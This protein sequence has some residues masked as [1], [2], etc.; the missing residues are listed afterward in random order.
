MTRRG[1]CRIVPIELICHKV[2][3]LVCCNERSRTNKMC[4]NARFTHGALCRRGHQQERL[5][6]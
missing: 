4:D 6:K 1:E 2:A 5:T 3:A